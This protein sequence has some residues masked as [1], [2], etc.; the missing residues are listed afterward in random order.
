M[1]ARNVYLVSCVHR[2]GNS[3]EDDLTPWWADLDVLDGAHGANLVLDEEHEEEQHELQAVFETRTVNWEAPGLW[4]YWPAEEARS[5]GMATEQWE[6]Y[7]AEERRLMD[8]ALW[9]GFHEW[10]MARSALDETRFNEAEWRL[11]QMEVVVHGF[12]F[13]SDCRRFS[14]LFEFEFDTTQTRVLRV[15]IAYRGPAFL[16]LRS[17]LLEEE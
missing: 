8:E 9:H 7:N 12:N 5:L 11:E 6:Q 16:I 10:L 1:C 15:R 17:D 13:I 14:V 3:V 4:N 2:T